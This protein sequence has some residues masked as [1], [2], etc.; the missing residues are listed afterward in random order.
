VSHK[1]CQE[2]RTS[3]LTIPVKIF[4]YFRIKFYSHHD[5]NVS[6]IE[7][8]VIALFC[9]KENNKVHYGK[10]KIIQ[11]LLQVIYIPFGNKWNNL[12]SG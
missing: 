10:H 7:L 2:E 5:E 3:E 8:D 12:N 11:T 6:D 1:G 9:L 4:R